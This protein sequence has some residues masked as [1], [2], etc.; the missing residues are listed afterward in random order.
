MKPLIKNMVALH[1]LVLFAKKIYN[2][3][4]DHNDFQTKSFAD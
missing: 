2:L 4:I 3:L 1:L